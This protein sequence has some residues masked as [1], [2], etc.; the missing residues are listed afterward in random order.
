MLLIMGMAPRHLCKY[1]L[2]FVAFAFSNIGALCLSGL[3]C[4]SVQNRIL[5]IGRNLH[6]KWANESS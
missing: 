2:P 4:L 5:E 6:T 1:R 3:H